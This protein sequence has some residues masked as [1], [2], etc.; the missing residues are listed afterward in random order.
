MKVNIQKVIHFRNI[1]TVFRLPI[2]IPIE[3][4]KLKS[5]NFLNLL[6]I[7]GK[8]FLNLFL[9]LGKIAFKLLVKFFNLDRDRVMISFNT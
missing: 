3:H 6:L 4:F 8:N 9:I 5:K 7:L 1:I 2:V